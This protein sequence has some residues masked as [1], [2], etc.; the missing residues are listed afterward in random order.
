MWKRLG[1]L[2]SNQYNSGRE[3]KKTYSEALGDDLGI[4]ESHD[5]HL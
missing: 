4:Q 2:D 3:K 1:N 5:P